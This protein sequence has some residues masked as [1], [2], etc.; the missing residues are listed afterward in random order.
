MV[1]KIQAH[2]IDLNALKKKVLHWKMPAATR[3][4][5]L[6][7]ITELDVG[8]VNRGKRISEGRQAKYLWSLRVMDPKI[9]TSS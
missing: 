3:A 9:R 1:L 8:K 5:V 7:F 2:P 4:D 6:R